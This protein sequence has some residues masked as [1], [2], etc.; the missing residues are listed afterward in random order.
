MLK[1]THLIT[2]TS[3]KTLKE[4]LSY[5]TPDLKDYHRDKIESRTKPRRVRH[6]II[7]N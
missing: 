1:N 3:T 5:K 6:G 4:G 2:I 7:R